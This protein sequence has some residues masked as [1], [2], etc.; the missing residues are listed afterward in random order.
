[1]T[2]AAEQLQD[3]AL[4]DAAPSVEDAA[5]EMGWRPKEEFKGDEAK[6]VD[7]ETF[8]KRGEEI[9]PILRAQS[10]KDR[11]AL[12]AARSEITEMKKTFKE[13]RQ[14]HSQTERRAYEKA[15]R[16]LEA[17]QA[18]AV[19]AG[20]LKAV[21]E[22]TKEMTDLSRDVQTD[23]NGDPYQSDDHKQNLAQWKLANAWFGTDEAMTGA[24]QAIANKLEA[25]GIQGKAQLDEVAKRIRSEFPH[26][27]ENERRRGPAAVEGASPPRKGGKTRSDLPAEA[28]SQMDKWVKQGLLTEAQ[29]LKD[30]QWS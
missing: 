18:E 4:S 27:F 7:A 30:Y 6:W 25:Q 1:M 29:F 28:R 24:A 2:D 22:I 21:R 10:K 17:R 20:D 8:V 14:Y 9:L 16:D 19:E 15:I 3:T 26:K 12:E 5:R 23:D 13:F 11:E